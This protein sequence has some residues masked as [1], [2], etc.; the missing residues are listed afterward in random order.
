MEV[1]N[2]KI[3][4]HGGNVYKIS[5]QLGVDICDVIDFS[6]NINPLGMPKSAEMAIYSS[7]DNIKHYPDPEYTNL[8]ISVSK[9]HNVPME[10]VI[11][12]NGAVEALFLFIRALSPKYGLV[13]T[14]SF[15]EYRRALE[16]VNSEYIPLYMQEKDS[17]IFKDFSISTS[18]LENKIKS[19]LDDKLFI[20]CNPNNP[21]G[22][23]T[24]SD[25]IDDIIKICQK[26]DVWLLIDEAFMDFAS[27][28]GARSV[29]SKFY[30]G[31]KIVSMHSIT[32]FYAVPALRFGYLICPNVD[33]RDK[34]LKV[35][36]VWG[37]N[38]F[39]QNYTI[40][41]LEDIE[42]FEQTKNWFLSQST[43]MNES[44]SALSGIDVYESWANYL[45]VKSHHKFDIREK[46][47]EKNLIIRD[48][49]NFDGLTR[50]YY[51]IAIRSYDENNKLVEALKKI[52]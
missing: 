30:E 18:E 32:K 5:R 29:V 44:L 21:T 1:F 37:V 20:L 50:E 17:S 51:R 33:M 28:K 35:S 7:F 49:S 10:W 23:L 4:T 8:K 9:H 42:Y 41:A 13:A 25:D 43:F 36:S 19:L 3:N 16:S 34:I 47:L 27:I 40:A 48:C 46:L 22:T 45:F 26:N 31:Q 38:I 15:I 14:P 12:C 6:A 11:P 52:L 39:A 2:N 24:S